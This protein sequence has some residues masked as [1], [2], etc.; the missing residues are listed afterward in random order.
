MVERIPKPFLAA[1]SPLKGLFLFFGQLFGA[2]PWGASLDDKTGYFGVLENIRKRALY[3]ID[4]GEARD[5]TCECRWREVVESG[6]NLESRPKGVRTC[7]T[8]NTPTIWMPK[9]G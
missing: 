8:A 4:T 3:F 2:F 1:K 9:E 7:F 5:Y 6:L